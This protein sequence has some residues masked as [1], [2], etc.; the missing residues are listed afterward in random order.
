VQ[1]FGPP[2]LHYQVKIFVGVE[3][4]GC[5]EETLLLPCRD[6]FL[7]KIDVKEKTFMGKTNP[8]A[9]WV[10]EGEVVVSYLIPDVVRARVG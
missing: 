2:E 7:H 6:H 5:V 1:L 8:S 10:M 9:P 3:R 4:E